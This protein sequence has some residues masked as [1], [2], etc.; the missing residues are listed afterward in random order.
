MSYAATLPARH[1]VAFE[2]SHVTHGGPSASPSG[3]P[4]T[5]SLMRLPAAARPLATAVYGLLFGK[6][7]GEVVAEQVAAAVAP[8]SA[9]EMAR[10]LR[11]AGLPVSGLAEIMGVERKTVYAWLDGS[12]ARNAKLGRLETLH[13]L[14]GGE[15]PGALKLFHR[16]WDRPLERSATLHELLTAEAIDVVR[17]RAALD[18]LRPSITRALE[19]EHKQEAEGGMDGG[20]PGLMNLHMV[21]TLK[22]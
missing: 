16:H 7:A 4:L 13:D 19:R 12:D 22:R 14:L 2:P 10:G 15:Q 17:V 20:P 21:A 3:K 11:E 18:A 9:T 5:V 8:L 6:L 1:A